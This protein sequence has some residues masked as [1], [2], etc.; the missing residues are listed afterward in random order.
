MRSPIRASI[1][2]FASVGL[3][4]ATSGCAWLARVNS[5][6][7]GA[8][9]AVGAAGPDVSHDG[10][11]VTFESSSSDLTAHPDNGYSDIFRRDVRTG[12]TEL[13]SVNLDGDGAN[14]NSS[15]PASISADGRYVAFHSWASDLV[16]GD[17][18][19][20]IYVRD[21][22]ADST[23]LVAENSYG[24][25]SVEHHGPVISANGRY[26]AYTRNAVSPGPVADVVDVYR[27]DLLTGITELVS[28]DASGG[29]ADGTSGTASMSADGRLVAFV[30]RASDLVVPADSNGF[31]DVYVRDMDADTTQRATDDT[32]GGDSNAGTQNAQITA[33]GHEV[34]FFSPASDLVASDTNGTSDLFVRDLTTDVT[35]LVVA[36]AEL[37]TNSPGLA[38]SISDDGRFV[39]FNTDAV[40][41]LP[42]GNPPGTFV[43]DRANGATAHVSANE[44][45]GDAGPNIE[46][47]LSGDGRYIAFRSITP[48]LRDDR[49]MDA[50]IY[51]RATFAPRVDVVAPASVARGA[52][53]TF[54]ISGEYFPPDT[55][56]WAYTDSGGVEIKM[57]GTV[58]VLS[59]TEVHATITV[60]HGVQGEP[61]HLVIVAPGPGPGRIEGSVG[62]C[63]ECSIL[64]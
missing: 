7:S 3:A 25:V 15:S 59:S 61:L 47:S 56:V 23:T 35:E 2:L 50:D 4:L 6:T 44:I 28:A 30:S 1:V 16:L 14:G 46:S 36:D 54:T 39:A 48:L 24:D 8:A 21:L 37:A 11:Y 13:V 27:Y 63:W 22:V 34:A 64:T 5:N 57:V 41:L 26:V 20:G 33:D 43:R 29:S 60:D 62:V 38:P 10:R 17:P 40:N 31:Y 49:N 52:T 51:L 32:A 12:V 9:P 58:D 42:E 55:E 45:G 53:E 19:G 18:N